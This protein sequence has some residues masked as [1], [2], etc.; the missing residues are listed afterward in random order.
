ME[1]PLVICYGNVSRGDD[2]AAHRVAEVLLHTAGV[3]VVPV[4]LLDVAL[5]EEVSSSKVAIF[6]DAERRAHPPVRVTRVVEAPLDA[7]SVHSLTP[8]GL[9]SLARALYGSAPVAHLVTIAAPEMGHGE[10]L[11]VTAEAASREAASVIIAMCEQ[12]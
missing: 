10:G 8:A 6:V 1:T 7:A 2:G 5:A 9:L 11:S 3:R 4:P 12:A